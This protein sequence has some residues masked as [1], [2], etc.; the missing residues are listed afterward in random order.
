MT[1]YNILNGR[2]TNATIMQYQVSQIEKG[3]VPRLLLK[4]LRIQETHSDKQ[5]QRLIRNTRFV[6]FFKPFL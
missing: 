5:A 1:G 2:Q 6:L 4:T 3:K